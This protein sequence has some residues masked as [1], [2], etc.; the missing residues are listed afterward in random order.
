MTSYGALIPLGGP[1]VCGLNRPY[2]TCRQRM[3]QHVRTFTQYCEATWITRSHTRPAAQRPYAYRARKTPEEVEEARLQR[4]LTSSLNTSLMPA[5]DT[6][7]MA[8]GG[9][10]GTFAKDLFLLMVGGKVLHAPYTTITRREQAPPYCTIALPQ[11]TGTCAQHTRPPCLTCRRFHGTA[12]ECCSMGHHTPGYVTRLPMLQ[13]CSQHNLVP[14]PR[15]MVTGRG[16]RQCCGMGHHKVT[17][18]QKPVARACPTENHGPPPKKRHANSQRPHTHTGHT[19]Y[20]LTPGT[21]QPSKRRQAT[22]MKTWTPP[23]PV[24]CSRRDMEEP[25]LNIPKARGT[26]RF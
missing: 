25:T 14:C 16:V 10:S 12:E 11:G 18:P 5:A 9:S 1:A 24:R 21:P 22:W 13:R 8:K 15:C 26:M 17:T 23:P 20:P 4:A 6:H 2:F 19:R 3:I 7:T